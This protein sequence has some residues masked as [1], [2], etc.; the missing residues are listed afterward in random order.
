M[1]H[2]KNKKSFKLCLDT[3]VIRDKGCIGHSCKEGKNLPKKIEIAAKTGYEA[4]EL[5]HKDVQM[6]LNEGN[7]PSD[8][9][10]ILDRYDLKVPSYKV[11]ENWDDFQ[12]MET[13][14]E[15][16]AKSCV[17]KVVRD[18][19]KG[20]IRSIERMADDYQQLI[21]KGLRM[22]VEPALEFMALSPSYNKIDDV[23]DIME[24]VEGGKLV[25]D[26]WHLWRKD[27]A[28]FTKFPFQRINSNWIS[29][30]HF[31][32]ARKDIPRQVQLDGHRKMPGLG[33]LNLQR[34]L[35]MMNSINFNGYLSLNVYDQSLW[36]LDPTLVAS[37]GFY[38]MRNLIKDYG[39]LR[40]GE[41]WKSKQK[42]RCEGLWVKQYQTHLDPRILK[43]DRD[44]QLE[45]ML[46][47]YLKNKSVMDFKC[48]FSPLAKFVSVGFDGFEGCIQYLKHEF[49]QANWTCQS[50]EDFSNNYR[51]PI[52]VL[53]HIGL[54]D[55]DTEIESHLKIRSNCNPSLII[56][57]CAADN[58]G[59]VDETKKGS[60][61][62]W[63][64]LK[65]GLRGGVEMLYET[66]M[67]ERNKRLLFIGRHDAKVF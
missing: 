11:M 52:D 60:R 56:I 2:I 9:K 25:L 58:D 32:D 6:F 43:T 14:A 57:E 50:D 51:E 42:E 27:D 53:M 17:V 8:L 7:K 39:M 64:I 46:E 47:P 59:K 33:V 23:C 49:P 38:N 15:I 31:T 22:G 63:E 19:H 35:K 24:R 28:N 30:V 36:D 66:N 16:G 45:N 48:G 10:N 3:Y 5:W 12:V 13:A 18:E 41:N 20:A 62:R 55:S 44:K 1:L 54:G 37:R 21:E 29:V 26:T 34:F 65:K 40:D 61:K 67:A 4:V